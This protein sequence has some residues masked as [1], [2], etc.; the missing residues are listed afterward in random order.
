MLVVG[1][2]VLEDVDTMVEVPSFPVL[3]LVTTVVLVL[4]ES[5]TVLD[6]VVNEVLGA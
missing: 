5:V 4:C 3:V 6:E 1:F 2:T